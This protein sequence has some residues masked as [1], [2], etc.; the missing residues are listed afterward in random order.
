M[1]AVVRRIPRDQRLRIT[2]KYEHQTLYFNG[3]VFEFLE[4]LMRERLTGEGTFR[5][6]QG[7]AYGLEFDL[8]T[9]VPQEQEPAV[10]K[11]ILDTPAI[12]P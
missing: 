4:H 6:N 10:V 12:Q 9:L 3:D 7:S 5:L 1:G 2:A 8:R 11:N